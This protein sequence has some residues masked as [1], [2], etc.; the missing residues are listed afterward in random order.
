MSFGSDE[1]RNRLKAKRDQHGERNDPHQN[2][3]EVWKTAV[4]E[5]ENACGQSAIGRKPLLGFI[6]DDR[7][8]GQVPVNV[9]C[10]GLD[11]GSKFAGFFGRRQFRL[12]E[13]SQGKEIR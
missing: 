8:L 3:F 10:K 4:N 1:E 12:A 9:V 13:R 2:K 11:I 5:F 7:R 6:S